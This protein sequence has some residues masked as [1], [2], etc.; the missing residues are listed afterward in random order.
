[1]NAN[2]AL[3][4]DLHEVQPEACPPNFDMDISYGSGSVEN[5]HAGDKLLGKR[6]FPALLLTAGQA[7][8]EV[9]TLVINI[10]IRFNRV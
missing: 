6:R 10:L 9:Q 3:G 1:M 7:N 4:K 5:V 2:P 8:I